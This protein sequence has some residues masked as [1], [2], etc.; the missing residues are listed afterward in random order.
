MQVL[1]SIYWSGFDF[2]MVANFR[3]VKN[4]TSKAM[5]QRFSWAAQLSSSTLIAMLWWSLYHYFY[6]D[7]ELASIMKRGLD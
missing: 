1:Y 4:L 3:L 7:R 6:E 5:I 2:P